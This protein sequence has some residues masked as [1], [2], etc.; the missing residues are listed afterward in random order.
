MATAKP[1]PPAVVLVRPQEEG[2][3][4][5]V[6]RAMV[7][8]GLE[9]LV[10]VEPAVALGGVAGARAVRARHVLAGA[11]RAP[12]LAAAL[13]GFALVAG[14]TSSRSRALG[15]PLLTPRELAA[16]LAGASPV[17]TALVFG[18]EAS[19]LTNEELALC[20]RLVRIPAAPR[21]PTLN[22]AQAVLVVAYEL[23]VA[24][25]RP[26]APPK[27]DAAPA[28]TAAV[29]GLFAQAVPLLAE[30]GFARDDT[31]AGVL[32]DLRRL[33][34]RSRLSRREVALLRGICRRTAGELAWRPGR[35][36]G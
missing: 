24:G 34:A 11:E 6:A 35:G 22:L 31:F 26:S 25:R 30:V 19:G 16:D 36:K 21:Q 20:G 27:G 1:P 5:A 4:G 3:V 32:R 29:E 18:P 9:R 15:I 33:A 10:L 8:M 12:S 23:F 28:T 17:P 13:A 7:N 14:T 2:N